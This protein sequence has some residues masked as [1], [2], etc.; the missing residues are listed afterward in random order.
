M[1]DSPEEPQRV[2]VP[3]ERV[4]VAMA[5]AARVCHVHRN[6]IT[7][8]VRSGYLT[9]YEQPPVGAYLVGKG[10]RRVNLGELLA[11]KQWHGVVMP[12]AFHEPLGVN[13]D[14]H[15]P[16]AEELRRRVRAV[17]AWFV[18]YRAHFLA[19]PP[20]DPDRKQFS[21][22]MD[23]MR[24][25]YKQLTGRRLRTRPADEGDQSIDQQEI[26]EDFGFAAGKL[27]SKPGRGRRA[28]TR[29][30]RAIAE[31]EEA[32]GSATSAGVARDLAGRWESFWG[33]ETD[34]GQDDEAAFLRLRERFAGSGQL[35]ANVRD[36]RRRRTLLQSMP[37]VAWC[38]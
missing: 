1:E 26:V 38:A 14:D 10:R 32:A 37:D 16:A 36:K 4:Y 23:N 17:A 33:A 6:T 13:P 19:L 7:N 3:V 31:R 20:D 25:L 5:E 8:W 21:Q 35:I 28:M 11:W 29:E 34:Q 12:P 27:G 18:L 2:R 22:L 15:S 9:V 24:Q 30:L